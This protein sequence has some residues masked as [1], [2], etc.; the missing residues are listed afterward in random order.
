M[1]AQS[2]QDLESLALE[3]PTTRP[4][5]LLQIEALRAASD[6]AWEAAATALERRPPSS[7][8][9]A[10]HQSQIPVDRKKLAQLTNQL[11]GTLKTV[12]TFDSVPVSDAISD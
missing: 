8:V 11:I 4:L 1:A 12:V 7:A 3:D 10:I 5:A 2:H 6:P 9:P